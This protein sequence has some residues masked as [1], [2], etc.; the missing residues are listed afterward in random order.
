MSPLSRYLAAIDV[1]TAALKRAGERREAIE[2]ATAIVYVR[3]LERA[4]AKYDQARDK[5]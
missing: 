1:I 5:E 4:K 2:P 3:T